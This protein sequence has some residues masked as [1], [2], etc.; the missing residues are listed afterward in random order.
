MLSEKRQYPTPHRVI[1]ALCRPA[2]RPSGL[3][4]RTGN[5]TLFECKLNFSIKNIWRWLAAFLHLFFLLF[6][7]LLAEELEVW[8]L[9]WWLWTWGTQLLPSLMWLVYLFPLGCQQEFSLSWQIFT[10]VFI[11][12]HSKCSLETLGVWKVEFIIWFISPVWMGTTDK[13]TFLVWILKFTSSQFS[14]Y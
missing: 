3:S 10:Y 5:E 8:M 14:F 12:V 6:L 9:C 13:F 4:L 11:R 1:Q 7:R 2:A